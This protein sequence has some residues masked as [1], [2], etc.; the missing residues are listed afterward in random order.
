M[1]APKGWATK[2]WAT[3]GIW[4]H[5]P[6]EKFEILMLWNTI[7]SVLRARGQFLSMNWSLNLFPFYAYFYLRGFAYKNL[8]LCCL[9]GSFLDFSFSE[10]YSVRS[11]TIS[12]IRIHLKI[13]EHMWKNQDFSY[14]DSRLVRDSGLV[15]K[16]DQESPDEI[17]MVGQSDNRCQKLVRTYS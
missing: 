10:I 15:L 16:Q 4:V 13:S 9:F 7:S 17:R 11:F 5:F 2:G 12:I 8:V 6:Q 3:K 14:P 1:Q